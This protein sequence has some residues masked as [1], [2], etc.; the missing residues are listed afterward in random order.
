MSDYVSCKSKNS[1]KSQKV[2]ANLNLRCSS[3]VQNKMY[4]NVAW[5][6]GNILSDNS[7]L[8]NSSISI[9]DDWH[10]G[11][12]VLSDVSDNDSESFSVSKNLILEKLHDSE[13]HAKSNVNYFEFAFFHYRREF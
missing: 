7:S 12:G 3:N 2:R 4:A 1:R 11:F 6:Q 5:A 13:K 9:V 8:G 10:K